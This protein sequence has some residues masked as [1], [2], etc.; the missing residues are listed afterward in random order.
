MKR[1]LAIALTLLVASPAWGELSIGATVTVL[2]QDSSGDPWTGTHTTDAN[3]NVLFALCQLA[4]GTKV[5]SDITFNSVSMTKV[6]E[7]AAVT[8]AHSYIWRL[9]TPSIGTFSF[10][11]DLD[12][13]DDGG[14]VFVNFIGANNT[15]PESGADSNSQTGG[16]SAMEVDI[17][18]AVGNYAIAVGGTG[19]LRTVT[20]GAD[21]T[22]WAN[23][24][25]GTG[26][27]NMSYEPGNGTN[28]MSFSWT[29]GNDLATIAGLCVNAA[30]SATRRNARIFFP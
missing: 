1:F 2:D 3:T 15:T 10:S 25:D 30:P 11:V 19:N 16:D 21:Q 20:V 7:S 14:C 18:C 24:D 23:Q 9:L 4:N 12:S 22:V 27:N 26:T 8:G 5:I 13:A 6:S 29:G 28:T 17:T